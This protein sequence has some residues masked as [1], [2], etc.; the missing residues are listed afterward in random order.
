[1]GNGKSAILTFFAVMSTLITDCLLLCILNNGS[2]STELLKA[3]CAKL[4][5][6]NFL[7]S[8]KLCTWLD[9]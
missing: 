6:F 2:R 8:T 5:Y 9:F 3:M 4:I 7:K 1:M